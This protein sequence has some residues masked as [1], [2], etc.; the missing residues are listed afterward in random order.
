MSAVRMA[1][2]QP[3]TAGACRALSNFSSPSSI[4][5]WRRARDPDLLVVGDDDQRHAA[6]H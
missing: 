5:N 6:L 4:I 1:P 2:D 3:A